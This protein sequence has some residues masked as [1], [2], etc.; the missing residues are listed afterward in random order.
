M[1][2]GSRSPFRDLFI[3]L[4]TTDAALLLLLYN[5][6]WPLVWRRG[7]W[8]TG[9]KEVVLVAAK[10]IYLHGVAQAIWRSSCGRTVARGLQDVVL[11]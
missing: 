5:V 1:T 8:G 6:A 9:Y 11:V 3:W 10:Y 2:I 7:N 4:T